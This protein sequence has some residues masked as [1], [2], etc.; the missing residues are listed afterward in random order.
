MNTYQTQIGGFIVSEFKV[1]AKYKVTDETG[2]CFAKGSVVVLAN[3]TPEKYPEGVSYNFTGVSRN[4]GFEVGQLLYTHQVEPVTVT[5][6]TVTRVSGETSGPKPRV[7][8][9]YVVE[10]ED[11]E[12]VYL[13]TFDRDHARE[14]KAYQG[15]K[16]AGVIITAYAAVK[17][18]R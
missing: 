16:K 12:A 5:K 4:Y 8:Y 18:I 10:D 15:G 1:G 13:K 7:T 14:E 11:G 9:L 3:A 17:E 2:H 6:A